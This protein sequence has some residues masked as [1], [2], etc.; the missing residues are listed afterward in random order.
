MDFGRK[1]MILSGETIITEGKIVILV[2][3]TN[4]LAE[5][6]DSKRKQM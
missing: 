6:H 3:I 2:K 5:N 4:V 1:A